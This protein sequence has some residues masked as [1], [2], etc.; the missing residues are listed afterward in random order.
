MAERLLL[1]E[2]GQSRFLSGTPAKRCDDLTSKLELW[3]A[4]A[5]RECR[6]GAAVSWESQG[7]GKHGFY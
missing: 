1:L 2:A 6:I 7:G 4:K 5:K 3:I